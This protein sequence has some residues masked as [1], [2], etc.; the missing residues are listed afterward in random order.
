MEWE[1]VSADLGEGAGMV[2]GVLLI[3]LLLQQEVMLG[4]RGKTGKLFRMDI[5]ASKLLMVQ[6]ITRSTTITMDTIIT[7]DTSR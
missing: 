5:Q 7:M 2:I 3:S 6:V 1:E 4:L